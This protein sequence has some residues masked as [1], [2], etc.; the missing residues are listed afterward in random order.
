MLDIAMILLL[1]ISFALFIV[2]T[3]WCS[4]VEDGGE[5]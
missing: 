4:K 2:F 3:H 5:A 1:A